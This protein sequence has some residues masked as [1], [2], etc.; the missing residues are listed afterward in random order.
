MDQTPEQQSAFAQ[1][2]SQVARSSQRLVRLENDAA[3]AEVR[4]QRASLGQ[5]E[6]YDSLGH[7]FALLG[8]ELERLRAA[9]A[10]F[11]RMSG[12]VML[13]FRELVKRDQLA[14]FD[15]RLRD[16]PL[17]SFITREEFSSLLAQ[18]FSGLR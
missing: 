12:G 3:E 17:E 11:T 2:Y 16:W 1:L 10:S 8:D 9:I 18:R 7:E 5:D 4:V 13:R 15:A 6:A 14:D